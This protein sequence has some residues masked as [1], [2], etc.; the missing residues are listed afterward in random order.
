[1]KSLQTRERSKRPTSVSLSL[2]RF[3]RCAHLLLNEK[4]QKEELESNEF[5]LRQQVHDYQLKAD[6]LEKKLL[7]QEQVFSL[8]REKWSREKSDLERRLQ[9]EVEKLNEE[10]E[11]IRIHSQHEIKNKITEIS[12]K[13]NQIQK[14]M[15]VSLPSLDT[16]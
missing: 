8:D 14:E 4:S 9:E 11:M 12:L 6:L 15:E 3:S 7:K 16:C 1:V 10:K 13:F 2:T 5:E